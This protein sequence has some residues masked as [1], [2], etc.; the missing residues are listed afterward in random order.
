MV[1]YF[2]GGNG[3]I[4]SISDIGANI[5]GILLVHRLVRDIWNRFNEFFA[6]LGGFPGS[7]GLPTDRRESLDDCLL[8]CRSL[9][10]DLLTNSGPSIMTGVSPVASAP[11][12][13]PVSG[14]AAAETQNITSTGD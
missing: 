4:S 2:L 8:D 11:S 9:L 10:A 6:G 3:D 1:N 12:M 13:A 5:D 14:A 7:P